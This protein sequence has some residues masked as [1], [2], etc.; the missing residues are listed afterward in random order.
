MAQTRVVIATTSQTF[1][2]PGTHWTSA[3][4]ASTFSDSVAGIASMVAEQ[5]TEGGDTVFTFRPR[6]GT[7]G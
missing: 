5:T 3:Q 6:T 2:L 7:K 4:V 1:T